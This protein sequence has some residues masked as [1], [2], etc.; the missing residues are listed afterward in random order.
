MQTWR[1]ILIRLEV[2]E[3]YAVL[4]RCREPRFLAGF[5]Y[6]DFHPPYPIASLS[7]R[8]GLGYYSTLLL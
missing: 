2:F 6:S 7:D 3:A 8:L 1:G 4:S 5:M